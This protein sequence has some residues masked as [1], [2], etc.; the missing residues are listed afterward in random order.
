MAG[1]AQ[2]GVALIG[3]TQAPHAP[4]SRRHWKVNSNV[5]VVSSVPVKTKFTTL[6]LGLAGLVGDRRPGATVSGALFVQVKPRRSIDITS[7]VGRTHLE[8]V[9]TVRPVTACG[10]GSW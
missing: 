7:C 2:V 3:L 1:D 10:D 4:P 9:T 8:G 5:A 6:V